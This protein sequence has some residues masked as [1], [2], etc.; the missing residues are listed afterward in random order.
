MLVAAVID[1]EEAIVP[2]I[3][4]TVIR[5]YDTETAH[6]EDFRNP[7]IDVKE[8]RRGAVLQF[9]EEKGVIAFVAPPQTFCELS[10]KKA[11][12]DKVKF[13]HL[14]A[15]V[16]FETFQKLLVHQ[17]VKVQDALPADEIAPSY[18]PV[19]NEI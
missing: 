13:Y 19:K 15:N 11:Q 4:G 6:Y 1:L 10:Y 2:F 12:A 16:K 14:T 3:D 5:I 8:G 7:A 9:A 18:V 17:L